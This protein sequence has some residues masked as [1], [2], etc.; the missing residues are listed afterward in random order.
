VTIVPRRCRTEIDYVDRTRT[1]ICITRSRLRVL[2]AGDTTKQRCLNVLTFPAKAT[3]PI[4][5]IRLKA[6]VRIERLC[7]GFGPGVDL[8][9]RPSRRFFLKRNFTRRGYLSPD[10]LQ[11][12]CL[13]QSA[14]ITPA[15][16]Q[17]RPDPKRVAHVFPQ[18]RVRKPT[19][20]AAPGQFDGRFCQ[21]GIG[22]V[23][24]PSAMRN[25][26]VFELEQPIPAQTTVSFATAFRST[27]SASSLRQ[28]PIGV[29]GRRRILRKAE[30]DR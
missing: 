1:R 26:A 10:V 2:A 3:Q 12:D 9:R 8:L 16:T 27:T 6:L 25:V 23:A 21:T 22:P 5:S 29:D 15:H 30:F 24:R 19:G 28:I 11:F 14:G 7:L 17:T 13:Y 18:N 20:T 4:T